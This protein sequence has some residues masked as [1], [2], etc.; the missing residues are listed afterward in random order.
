[1][2][3]LIIPANE[4]GSPAVKW[5]DNGDGT[6]SRTVYLSGT[7]GGNDLVLPYG[8]VGTPAVRWHDN[9]DGS[10]SEVVWGG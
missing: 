4:K 7:S 2:A 3:D 1:M 9:G 6:F 8:K 10:Y 5:H